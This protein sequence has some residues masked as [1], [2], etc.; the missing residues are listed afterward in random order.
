MVLGLSI[1]IWLLIR[2]APSAC[3]Q[4]RD[5]PHGDCLQGEPGTVDCGLGG[6]SALL[7]SLSG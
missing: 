5:V 3:E 6:D 7:L 2:S 4:A 1:H